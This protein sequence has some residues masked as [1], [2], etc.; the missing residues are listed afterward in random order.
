MA[1][2]EHPAPSRINPHTPGTAAWVTDCKRRLAE[3][4]AIDL[5]EEKNGLAY[6]PHEAIRQRLIDATG[7]CFDWT[8]DQ[9][10]FRDDGVTRRAKDRATG[11][12]PRPLSMVVVGRLA[13]PELGTRAGIGA[14]PL[15][16]GAGED[17]A[18]KSAESDAL[19]RAAMAFG[20]GLEQLYL[21]T[22][23]A[24]RWQTP[25]PAARRGF[26]PALSDCGWQQEWQARIDRALAMPNGTGKAAWQ[27]LV[28][29]ALAHRSEERLAMLVR[30]ARTPEAAQAIVRRAERCGMSAGQTANSQPNVVA[31]Q[32]PI[33]RA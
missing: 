7:N 13:I 29:E 1:L 14:H 30:K 31:S 32:G 4:F 15:D 6:L 20:V 9:I 18:Y 3:P 19:K 21:Q 26:Q 27:Q 17:A 5:I 23:E 16:A 33:S 10:L 22:G 8:I 2:P 25:R 28:R 11:E 12:T 24:K